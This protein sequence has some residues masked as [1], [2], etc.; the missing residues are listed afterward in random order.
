MLEH[1]H[2]VVEPLTRFDRTSLDVKSHD[3]VVAQVDVV[4]RF[5]ATFGTVHEDRPGALPPGVA[6]AGTASAAG[7]LVRAKIERDQADLPRRLEAWAARRSEDLSADLVASE[8]TDGPYL[9]GYT[10]PCADCAGLGQVGC[11]GCAATGWQTCWQCHGRAVVNCHRCG[12]SGDSACGTCGGRGSLQVQ[13]QRSVWD[14]ASQSYRNETEWR[15]ETCTSCRYGRVSCGG[16]LGSGRVTCNQCHAGRVTC[17]E[18]RGAGTLGCSPCDK[19]GRF[20][21]ILASQCVVA[22]RLNVSAAVPWGEAKIFLEAIK[23]ITSLAALG[24]FQVVA[25]RAYSAGLE[26]H[27]AG[28]VQVSRMRLG[29]GGQEIDLI[30][31]GP[32]CRV[33]DFKN[34][35]GH[36]LQADLE[37]LTSAVAAAP[38]LTLSHLPQLDEA[39]SRFLASEANASLMGLAQRHDTAASSPLAEHENL[40]SSTYAQAAASALRQSAG[41]TVSGDRFRAFLL[42]PTA[43]VATFLAGLVLPSTRPWALIAGACIGCV[44]GLLVPWWLR[45]R[46]RKRFEPIAAS[47]ICELSVTRPWSIGVTVA[48]VSVVAVSAYAIVRWSPA[49]HLWPL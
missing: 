34:L 37:D 18:C 32:L 5:D 41:L 16:C 23:D 3:L 14:A 11:N 30:G 36:L 39:L 28:S 1:V 33:F 2:A 9:A 12:G 48:S 35:V 4:V 46:M 25:S 20:S 27:I 22:T 15:T 21:E 49:L 6:A 47:R 17:V 10:R 13:H 42:F 26:R 44:S 24:S 40:V 29:A 38:R 43:A 8:C 31:F 7:D 45:H 19:T